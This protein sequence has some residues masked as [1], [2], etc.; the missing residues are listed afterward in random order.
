[1]DLQALADWMKRNG[2][3]RA[4]LADGTELEFAR[5][6]SPPAEPKREPTSEERASDALAKKRR[7]YERELGVKLSDDQLRGLP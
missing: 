4:R 6:F 1:M 2:V 5:D 3:R 7:Q